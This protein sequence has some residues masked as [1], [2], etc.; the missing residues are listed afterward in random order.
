MAALKAMAG[1]GGIWQPARVRWL[2]GSRAK[3]TPIELFMQGAWRPVE[4]LAEEIRQGPEPGDPRRRRYWL[5]IDDAT[6]LLEGPFEQG[7]WKL[8]PL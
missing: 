4:L 3:Q 5:R 6:Y 8:R 1:D 7:D 2:E